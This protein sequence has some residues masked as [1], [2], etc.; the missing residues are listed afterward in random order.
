MTIGKLRFREFY[1][2]QFHFVFYFSLRK[3][4]RPLARR[5]GFLLFVICSQ[6]SYK[7]FWPHFILQVINYKA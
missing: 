4:A 2:N 6:T 1:P 3:P 5:T 7:A